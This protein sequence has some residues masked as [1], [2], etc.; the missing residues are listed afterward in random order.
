MRPEHARQGD[1]FMKSAVRRKGVMNCCIPDTPQPVLHC[2][3]SLRR[4]K[5][6]PESAI[7]DA[8]RP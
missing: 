1:G 5:K 8:F 4:K 7:S 3:K 6:G 2:G